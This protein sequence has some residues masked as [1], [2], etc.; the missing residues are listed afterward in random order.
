M[1]ENGFFYQ[2]IA[3]AKRA[4]ETLKNEGHSV[5]V[6]RVIHQDHGP[7]WGLYVREVR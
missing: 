3:D 5:Q 7:G 1:D 6:K 4:G 2:S